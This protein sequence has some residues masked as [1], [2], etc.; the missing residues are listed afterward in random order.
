[1][2]DKESNPQGLSPGDFLSGKCDIETS[3]LESQHKEIKIDE[4]RKVG[5]H[6]RLNLR[7]PDDLITLPY[8]ICS[9]MNAEYSKVIWEIKGR[10]AS[11]VR[12]PDKAD[13]ESRRRYIDKMTEIM[14]NEVKP[15]RYELADEAM[16]QGD[17]A[18]INLLK[19]EL[20]SI[21]Y[22][23]G[24]LRSVIILMWCSIEVFMRDLWETSLNIGGKTII[25]NVLE[26]L[27]KLRSE[28]DAYNIQGKFI[29]RIFGKI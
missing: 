21:P 7:M 22:Y 6:L 3:I 5:E 18:F 29:N 25:G 28:Q 24:I 4:L 20:I 11:G 12:F 19:S 9:F 23:K 15:K 14:E 8:V 17:K 27:G 26:V 16:E 1:M 10:L 13:E 2:T